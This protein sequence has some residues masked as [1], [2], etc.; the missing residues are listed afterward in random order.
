MNSFLYY[1]SWT[2]FLGFIFYFLA[3][4]QLHLKELMHINANVL[5]YYLFSIF[6]P[7]VVAMLFGLPK[8][9]EKWRNEQHGSYHVKKLI[10]VNG[11]ILL[12]IMALIYTYIFEWENSLFLSLLLKVDKVIFITI[13]G[14]VFGYVLIDCVKAKPNHNQTVL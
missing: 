11:P 13:V 12:F 7:I 10:A 14:I 2:I 8:L 5:P 3:M 9:I 4:M 6:S 1:F